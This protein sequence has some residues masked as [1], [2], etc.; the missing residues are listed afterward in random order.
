MGSISV[1]TQLT[2]LIA[3]EKNT[4]LLEVLRSILT[5]PGH[6]ALLKAKLTARALKAED[7]LSA[8]RTH[9]L[10]EVRSRI[11]ARKER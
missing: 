4:G 7:D 1:R 3:K 11:E 2:E 6:D 8:G 5:S 9:G 10:D